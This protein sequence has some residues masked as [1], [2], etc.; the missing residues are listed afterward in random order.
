MPKKKPQVYSLKEAPKPRKKPGGHSK[1]TSTRTLRKVQRMYEVT[2]LKEQGYSHTEIAEALKLSPMEVGKLLREC[3]E[4]TI[5]EVAETTEQARQMEIARLDRLVKTYHHY[6]H[7]VHTEIRINPMTGMEV[8]VEMPPDPKYAKLLLDVSTRRSKLL[9]LDVPEVKK[10]ETTG[11][12]E[13]IGVDI[14]KV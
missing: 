2:H 7:D 14:S 10:I 12:R 9:A 3:L 1:L 4:L 11:I 13:Y 5:S 8:L 6:A